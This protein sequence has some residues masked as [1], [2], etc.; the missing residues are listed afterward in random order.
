MS[1]TPLKSIKFPGLGDTYT[2]PV[3]DN[4]LSV[5]GA[6]ADAKK[7]GDELTDLKADLKYQIP[8]KYNQFIVDANSTHSSVLDKITIDI[9]KDED[10]LIVTNAGQVLA[11]YSDGTS[12]SLAPINTKIVEGKALN[13]ITSI[14]V[15]VNNTSSSS[16]KI[17]FGVYKSHIG[18]GMYTSNLAREINN[19][20]N[21]D[22]LAGAGKQTFYTY[23][24]FV[25]G[26]LKT[27]GTIELGQPYR[28]SCSDHIIAKWDLEINVDS[29]F[30][31]G[32]IPFVNDT[33]GAWSG[34]KTSTFTIPAETEFVLQLARVTEITS[35]V[36][37][38][39]TFV[40]AVT[41]KTYPIN[42]VEKSFTY[43]LDISGNCGLHFTWYY[44]NNKLTV[45]KT[46]DYPLSNL[47]KIRIGKGTIIN[48]D[49]G[50][51]YKYYLIG[52]DGSVISATNAWISGNSTVI[53]HDCYLY[54]SFSANDGSAVQTKES[55]LSH[56]SIEAVTIR[57]IFYNDINEI[58]ETYDYYYDGERLPINT[59]RYNIIDTFIAPLNLTNVDVGNAQSFQG[60]TYYNEIIFQMYSDNALVLIDYNTNEILAKLETET[61]HSNVI[62]FTNSFYDVNDEFPIAIVA[63]GVSNKAF[64]IRIQR[65]GV[66]TLQSIVFP[67]QSCGNFVSTMIDNLNGVIYTVGYTENSYHE[68]PNGTNK[69]IFA[70][71]DLLD[72]TDNG[73]GTFTPAFIDSFNTPF[74]LTIQGPC[75]Y[76]GL[77]YVVSSH[78]ANSS[79]LIYV[80]DPDGRRIR[81]I[82]SDF[83]SAIKAHEAE[84]ICFATINGKECGIIYAAGANYHLLQFNS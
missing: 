50:Y 39:D 71:W 55:L 8:V 37:D 63:D 44:T 69:M 25:N 57:D 10:Y 16:V 38:V 26:G 62:A 79:T 81:N 74:I 60:F 58:T 78:W 33:A 6:A 80:I 22:K 53:N 67:V 3:V 56:F 5:S 13:K 27:N 48:C 65:T 19:I 28:V 70:K 42:L 15:Y 29:G 7:T 21:D 36:A 41:F 52:L 47:R 40:N 24:N 68:D 30:K 17:I 84:G 18:A 72:M 20:K 4:T 11:Y 73:D 77:L 59:G 64:K 46:S 51:R 1:N 75:Y 82:I 2:V 76:N 9:E 54:F 14:G 34:W 32:Y 43:Q 66:T 35:E 12:G 83:P 61:L 23:A 45:S 31:C 49:S